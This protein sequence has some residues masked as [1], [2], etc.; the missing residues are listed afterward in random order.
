M[1]TAPDIQ[2][3]TKDPDI[4]WGFNTDPNGVPFDLADVNND[5]ISDVDRLVLFAAEN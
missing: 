3:T 2:L 4:V 1:L 5:A